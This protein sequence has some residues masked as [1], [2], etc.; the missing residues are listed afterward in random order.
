M[1]KY[2]ILFLL[3]MLSV[4]SSGQQRKSFDIFSY[5]APAGFVLKEQKERLLY[6]KR[7]GNSFCQI[8]IWAAQQGSSDPAANFK[9]DWEH[10]AVKPY[11]LTEPPTTQ[12]EKQNGWEVVTGASQAAMD[13]IPFIVAVSTFTQNDISWCAVSIFNDEEY[14]AVIDKFILG[15]KAD[16]RKLVRKPNQATQQNNIPVSN[17]NNG[18]ITNSTTNFDDGWTA[19]VNNDYVKL[20]KAGTE[21]R[22]HYTDKALDDA[23]PNTIDA[24]EYYW[25]K[26]VEPYFNVS[27]VQK[28]SGVQ[29]PVI[30]HIQANAI[31]KK[32]GKSCFVAIKIVYSGGARPVVVIA[33]DQNSYQQQFPHPND[34]DPMLNA[35]RFAL[36]ANDI[37]GTWKGSGGGGVEY[38]NVYSGTYAGMSAVSSTDEFTFNSNGTYSSTYRSASMN[39][40][41]AQF[42]GQDY[43]GNFSV[44]DWSLTVTN[45][46]KAKTTTYKAQLIAV[47]GG[48]LLYMEDSDNS[49]MKYTLFKTK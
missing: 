46:Y 15:I 34:I 24:P 7:E 41:G 16:S 37:F 30:Y 17:N 48:F 44:T 49:S 2:S 38:Y 32:T 23:R 22:L 13:G 47:K 10:F 21:L 1:K 28:W 14:A 6:E 33:P 43:K 26:Y 4:F 3:L 9:T 42:G 19:I 12:T 39:S 35:N 45:R 36:T 18:G 5:S 11:N 27:N 31:E 8:H 40:G 20:T 25:S 29:Y